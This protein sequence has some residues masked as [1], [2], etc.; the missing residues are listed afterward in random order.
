MTNPH[1][2]LVPPT[3]VIGTVAARQHPPRR[4]RNAEVRAREY[5]TDGEVARLINTAGQNRHGHRDATAVLVAYRHGLRA[6]ELVTLRWDAIDFAHGRV[7]VHRVKGSA[8]IG[9]SIVRPRV[10]GVTP[11]QARPG[12]SVAVYLYVRARRAV[13]AGGLS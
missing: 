6:A 7:H 12:P 10:A 3:T 11:A 4:K 5:L 2:A 8:E 1:L 13:H 9:S